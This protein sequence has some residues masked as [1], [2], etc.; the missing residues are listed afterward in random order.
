MSITVHYFASLK[1]RLGR[2]SDNVD[3]APDLTVLDVWTLANPDLPL[4]T[5][6]LVAVNMDYVTL[7]T[8]VADA[9]TV[10]FFPPVT[11]G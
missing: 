9:D 2:A 6:I 7:T 8:S 5:A 11:G 1:E 4:P 3:F 10:A